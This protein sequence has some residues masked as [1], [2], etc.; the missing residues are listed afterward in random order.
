MPRLISRE[1]SGAGGAA[2]DGVQPAREC[3]TVYDIRETDHNKCKANSHAGF[4]HTCAL[5]S[6]PR[7]P[8]AAGGAQA[9][10]NSEGMLL[11]LQHGLFARACKDAA[12]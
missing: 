10:G 5:M 12:K 3:T 6:P 9:Y 4:I 2:G 7:G 8:A 1:A 11:Y